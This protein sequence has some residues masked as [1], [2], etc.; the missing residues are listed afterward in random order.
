MSFVTDV[1]TGLAEE[2][3]STIRIWPASEGEGGEGQYY[4]FDFVLDGTDITW[5]LNECL[6]AGCEFD[7]PDT[8]VMTASE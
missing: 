7:I 4:A 2:E 8:V 6:P 1:M 5:T 3:G